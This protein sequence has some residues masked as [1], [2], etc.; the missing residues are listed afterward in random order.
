MFFPSTDEA[1]EAPLSVADMQSLRDLLGDA[2]QAHQSI[3]ML[4]IG[5]QRS[6]L[7]IGEGESGHP[8][9]VV[10]HMMLGMDLLA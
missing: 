3:A 7:L 1:L 2:I 6:R 4:D 5:N 9:P 10:H 8:Q